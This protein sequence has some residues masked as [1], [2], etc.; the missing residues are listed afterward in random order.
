MKLLLPVLF[1][2]LGGCTTVPQNQPLDWSPYIPQIRRSLEFASNAAE[3]RRFFSEFVEDDGDPEERM[4]RFYEV[5]GENVSSAV[6]SMRDPYSNQ[7]SLT[8]NR[9]M[10]IFVQQVNRRVFSGGS[11]VEMQDVVR[12][13]EEGKFLKVTVEAP[14]IL[15]GYVYIMKDPI[16]GRSTAE[17]TF[18]DFI[19]AGY[20]TRKL[21]I[22]ALIGL[23]ED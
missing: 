10:N 5:L 22:S 2:L 17:Q 6:L 11:I 4:V 16:E 19:R 18:V 1:L 15:N 13:S 14:G 23:L 20:E 7:I 12:V 8:L 9:N 21:S 3:T